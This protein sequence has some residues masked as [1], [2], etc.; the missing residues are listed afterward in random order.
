MHSIYNP[1]KDLLDSIPA[2]H[3]PALDTAISGQSIQMITGGHIT[4]IG[5]TLFPFV[6]SDA[7]TGERLRIVLHAIVVP[8]LLVGM[9]IGNPVDFVRSQVW[10]SDGVMFTFGFGQG[11]PRRVRG[12]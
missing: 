1:L 2:E 8:R 5:T 10:D 9:F 6:L 7:E 12:M 11:G 4:S 3:R